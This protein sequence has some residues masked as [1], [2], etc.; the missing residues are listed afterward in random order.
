MKEGQNRSVFSLL[1]ENSLERAAKS[2]RYA[3]QLIPQV[4]RGPEF[5]LP[6][7][8]RLPAVIIEEASSCCVVSVEERTWGVVW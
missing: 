4:E 1:V 7:S 6:L 8:A 3:V 5:P 2:L